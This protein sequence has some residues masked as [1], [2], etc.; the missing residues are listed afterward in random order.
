MGRAFGAEGT[1]WASAQP[2]ESRLGERGSPGSGS[3]GPAGVGLAVH[4]PL[5]LV[6]SVLSPA[7]TDCVSQLAQALTP[8]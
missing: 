5:E 3:Q 4:T 6:S 7:L 1:G 8:P 2:S